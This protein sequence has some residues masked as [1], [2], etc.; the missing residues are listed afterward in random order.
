[1][2]NSETKREVEDN[3]NTGNPED[4]KSDQTED[5]NENFIKSESTS[6]SEKVETSNENEKLNLEL[7][8]NANVEQVISLDSNIIP[9][10]QVTDLDDIDVICKSDEGERTVKK[11]DEEITTSEQ[12]VTEKDKENDENLQQKLVEGIT[13]E[14]NIDLKKDDLEIRTNN[15]DEKEIYTNFEEKLVDEIILEH[16]QENIGL[17]SKLQQTES[18]KFRGGKEKSKN[19]EKR[20]TFLEQNLDDEENDFNVQSA[21]SNESKV[22]WEI[23]SETKSDDVVSEVKNERKK[24]ETPG[25][26]Y[27]SNVSSAEA[28]DIW[29]EY[30]EVSSEEMTGW[31]DSSRDKS[32]FMNFLQERQREKTI[33]I[34]DFNDFPT[35]SPTGVSSAHA[36]P[37]QCNHMC[38]SLFGSCG[39]VRQ[40]ALVQTFSQARAY[41]NDSYTGPVSLTEILQ[42]REHGLNDNTWG[43]EERMCKSRELDEDLRSLMGN[44]A[45]S[46]NPLRNNEAKNGYGVLAANSD[47]YEYVKTGVLG[48]LQQE[49]KE[50]E[51]KAVD[52]NNEVVALQKDVKR[53]EQEILR[54]QREVHKLKV[55]PC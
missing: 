24:S 7:D 21:K 39:S 42:E 35:M 55:S 16:K 51:N 13:S 40:E 32:V 12:D 45:S 41:E 30:K 9:D 17:E 20:V 19:K 53:K 18:V 4:I 54:L 27:R 29:K 37:T 15:E 8:A 26:E 6:Q 34:S 1:M 43:S 23:V 25:D 10:T 31:D 3:N 2:E 52:L 50:W 28:K 47:T 48:L 44:G 22:V 38:G 11:S 5:A 49:T 36:L 14:E 33:S 46:S